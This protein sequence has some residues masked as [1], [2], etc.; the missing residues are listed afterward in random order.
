MII[1]WIKIKGFRNFD[2]EKIMLANQTLVIGA[3]DV[4]KTNLITAL[5]LLFDRSL[6]DKDLDLFESDYNVYTETD[7]I[8]ITVKI[9]EI[10][11]DC[12]ISVFKGDIKNQTVYLQYRNTKTGDY[13]IC[14][15]HS[16]ETLQ[17]R[18]SR[19]YIK[20]LNMEYVNTNRNLATFMKRE[21]KQILEDTKQ[22]LPE[23]KMELDN[24]STQEIKKYLNKVNEKVDNLNYVRE[25]LNKVNSELSAL[26]I[27]NEGKQL[28]FKNANSD[29]TKMLDNLELT[30]NTEDGALTIGGD[31]RNNQ[32]FLA[33]WISKQKNIETLEK[34][35]FYAIEEPEAHLHPQQQRKLSSYLLENFSEQVF[36]TTHSPYIATEFRPNKIVKLNSKGKSTKVAKG[37]CSNDI[38]LNFNDFGYR[39]DAI[40]SD[41]FFVNAVL[42][43]EGPSEKLFYTAL[44]K[45]INIDLDRLNISILSVDGVGFKPYIKICLALDIPFVLRTDNDIFSKSKDKVGYY[46]QAG[47]SRVMGI[48]MELLQ[49]HEEEELKEY[50]EK[51]HIK[52]EWLK[53]CTKPDEATE[54]AQ[55]I[56]K[57]VKHNFNIYLSDVDLE[58]DLVNSNLYA[59]LQGFYNTLNTQDTIAK[60]QNAKAENMLKFLEKHFDDLGCLE[61]EGISEPIKRIA[62]I[63]VTIDGDNNESDY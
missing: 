58:N 45:K 22:L 8:E 24:T 2:D 60:M 6:S 13:S 52:N 23:E 62:E 9:N 19:F 61:N 30:Y 63:I 54:L 16:E 57:E 56:I 51:N 20:R 12:L 41:I 7:N 1:E 59:S 15:G 32:I 49:K 36:I 18:N 42:L 47:I 17:E 27:H 33:T 44:A 21:K 31:G 14:S 39:L 3:N 25:S 43:V 11:E 46:F 34:V 40:T 26:A 4:G 38:A 50:W 29:F 55:H 53:E 48:Y 10:Q 35:T 5:R 28:V 37:G